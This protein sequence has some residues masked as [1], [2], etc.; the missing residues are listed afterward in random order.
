MYGS[1]AGSLKLVHEFLLKANWGLDGWHNEIHEVY[2]YATLATHK[3]IIAKVAKVHNISY[4][5]EA[6]E[7]YVQCDYPTHTAEDIEIIHGFG[8]AKGDELNCCAYPPTNML[9]KIIVKP[10]V[11]DR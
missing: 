11:E 9:L 2:A 6:A 10:S 7:E 5:F 3:A 4:M 8:C 1:R